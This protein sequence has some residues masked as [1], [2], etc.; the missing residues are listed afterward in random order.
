MI[1]DPSLV[2]GAVHAR[3]NGQWSHPSGGGEPHGQFPIHATGELL[4]P[5]GFG[6]ARPVGQCLRIDGIE[7]LQYRG[8]PCPFMEPI[9]RWHRRGASQ[10]LVQAGAVHHVDADIGG[11]RPDRSTK[12][13]SAH[14]VVVIGVGDEFAMAMAKP[15]IAGFAH[16]R[17]VKRHLTV[18]GVVGKGSGKAE[19]RRAH[20]D[21]F[22]VRIRLRV[23]GLQCLMQAGGPQAQRRH[24]N[25]HQGLAQQLS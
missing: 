20:N 4:V 15:H 12:P 2:V 1:A 9:R 10:S 17:F 11:E 18:T 16:T 6:Q 14:G 19:I 23:D 22:K 3:L 13:M 24:H 25:R 8:I 7:L 5:S 21:H